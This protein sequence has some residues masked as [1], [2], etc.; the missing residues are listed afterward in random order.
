MHL[1]RE[2]FRQVF[3]T[4]TRE[5]P[6][7]VTSLPSAGRVSLMHQ[8]GQN[9]HVLH[10]LYFTPH[11]R[12]GDALPSWGIKDVEVV[13]DIPVQHSVSVS[14][15]LTEPIQRVVLEPQGEEV[16]FTISGDRV[17]FE[18]PELAGHQMVVLQ[19]HS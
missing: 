8:P 19:A 3:N 1:Y 5:E 11:K 9:R 4:L 12:G 2:F 10:L 16:T 14:L 6:Q 15:R 7:V 18:I 13:E 17:S